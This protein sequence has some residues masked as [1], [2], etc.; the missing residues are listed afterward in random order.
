MTV[1]NIRKRLE[2]LER[3]ESEAQKLVVIRTIERPGKYQVEGLR[4]SVGDKSTTY[5]GVDRI[6]LLREA[7]DDHGD[8]PVGDNSLRVVGYWL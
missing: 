4:L 3:A 2:Q 1:S 6:N 5:Q 7:L 8:F